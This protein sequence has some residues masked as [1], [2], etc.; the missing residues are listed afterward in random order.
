MALIANQKEIFAQFGQRII[1]EIIA[2]S[3]A[4]G[5]QASGETYKRFRL[6][7]RPNGF[8]IFGA[9]YLGALVEGRGP[10]KRRGG[11]GGESL[12]DRIMQWIQVK[13]VRADIPPRSLA[14]AIA[15]KIHKEGTLLFREGRNT[16]ILEDVINKNRIAAFAG[17]FA[18]DV[19]IDLSSDLIKTL[20]S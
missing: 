6:E 1:D 9:G 19:A 12:V 3:Q 5:Q 8:T 10:T 4:A 2:A 7:V 18:R 20:K 13:G 15:T 14:W 17:A 16:R 11:G